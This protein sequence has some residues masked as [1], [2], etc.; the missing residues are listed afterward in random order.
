MLK[1][2]KQFPLSESTRKWRSWR[3]ARETVQQQAAPTVG[4]STA[5]DASISESV[6]IYRASLPP[7]SSPP[8]PVVHSPL[9]WL[10]PMPASGPPPGGSSFALP[11]RGG[12]IL[13]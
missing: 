1:K 4:P 13:T 10:P 11:S 5:P 2:W 3:K 12:T 8:A 9:A 7:P 6:R